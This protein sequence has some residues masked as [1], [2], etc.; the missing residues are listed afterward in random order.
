MI[1]AFKKIWQFAGAERKNINQSVAVSF[2]NAL[3]RMFEVGAVYFIIVAL[4]GGETGGWP[5]WVALGFMLVSIIG[6]AVTASISKMQQTHAGYFMAA[7]ERIKIGNLLK[8]VPMGF[9]NE[10][11]LGEVTGVCTTVLG[12]IE[13]MVPIVLVNILSGLVGTV[14]FTAMI[15]I[16]DWRIGLIAA[17]GIVLYCLVLSSME[18][19]SAVLAPDSQ[20]SQTALTSAVLEYVQGMSV[21]KSFNLS[22]KG[23]KKLQDAL[24]YNRKSNLNMEKLLTPYSTCRS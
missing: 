18:R 19:K 10:N 24:E 12:N 17:A 15:L 7:N 6:N 5:A 23:D 11:S 4:T 22:G 8:G 16:F 20:K 1:S 9:F 13:T 3:S 21:V 14:V 2:L